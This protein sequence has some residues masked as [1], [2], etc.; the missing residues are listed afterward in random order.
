MVT[1]FG[2][3]TN[4]EARGHP[5]PAPV[6]L[7]RLVALVALY[8][9]SRHQTIPSK[10]ASSKETAE[11]VQAGLGRIAAATPYAAA[12]A[13]AVTEMWGKVSVGQM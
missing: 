6:Y 11:L 3:A 7:L 10:E 9:S 1:T 12:T 13:N 5:Q 8:S 4:Q 2:V